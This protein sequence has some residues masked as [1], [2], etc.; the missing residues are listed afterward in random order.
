MNSRS[1]LFGC[2]IGGSVAYWHSPLNPH[3]R[4][5]LVEFVR[6]FLVSFFRRPH[7]Q[8]VRK[9][10]MRCVAKVQDDNYRPQLGYH[11]HPEAAQT[12]TRMSNFIDD[13]IVFEIG[14]EPYAVSMSS[15]EQ[16]SG[17]DGSRTFHWAKDLRSDMRHDPVRSTHVYTMKDVDYHIPDVNDYLDGHS[18]LIST[19][20]PQ[21]VAGQV[22]PDASFCFRD[23]RLQMYIN[24]YA[25]FDHEIWDYRRDE[26]YVH[27]WW[28]AVEYHVDSYRVDDTRALVCISPVCTIYGPAG[29][30]FP[31][32]P[33]K[34]LRPLDNGFNTLTRLEAGNVVYSI[35][36]DGSFFGTNITHQELLSLATRRQ[37][38]ANGKP[39]M[40]YDTKASLTEGTLW[41]DPSF[42]HTKN[43]DAKTLVH[44]YIHSR[45]YIAPPVPYAGRRDL[46]TYHPASTP[47]DEEVKPTMTARFPNL[48][49]P[50]S[51]ALA[52]AS[53][54]E[55]DVATV[56]T[57][58]TDLH[59]NKKT[60]GYIRRY[61]FEFVRSVV[62]P[63][64]VEPLD[65]DAVRELQN[66]PSQ[67]S[68]FDQFSALMD[69]VLPP[70][71]SSFMKKES[72]ADGKPARNITQM[73]PV[74]RVNYSRYT[75][76][77]ANALKRHCWYVSG[78]NPQE[79]ANLVHAKVRGASCVQ[80]SDFKKMD[81]TTPIMTTDLV[82][83]V[84]IRAY[85]EQYHAEIRRYN[86]DTINKP[87]TTTHGV[88]YNTGVGTLS[89]RP[90]TSIRSTLTN[91]FL[92]Y[93]ACRQRGFSE[94]ESHGRLGL[95]SGDDGLTPD[96]HF[97]TFRRVCSSVG[98]SVT[99]E[100]RKPGDTMT[101]LGRIY[102]DAWSGPES[103]C[104][105]KRILRRL[106]LVIGGDISDVEYNDRLRAKAEGLLVTDPETPVVVDA[107]RA[108]LRL[109]P[110]GNGTAHQNEQ[111]WWA[112]YR[113]SPFPQRSWAENVSFV[114]NALDTTTATVDHITNEYMNATT[115]EQLC[116]M[117][118]ILS[119]A[120]DSD[121][122]VIVG[123]EIINESK[124]GIVK[125]PA[126]PPN[127]ETADAPQTKEEDAPAP[128]TSSKRRRR[129]P[130]KGNA[131]PSAE[132][133]QS[134]S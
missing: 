110:R 17:I 133:N 61:M 46:V 75:I 79:I 10:F 93:C 123:G 116:S 18:L 100:E 68:G 96:G 9:A 90:D 1:I 56:K 24:G 73:D 99:N 83:A 62:E 38:K 70:K 33:I 54:R 81:G 29:W 30:L 109:V 103:I 57:R 102:L 114:A 14:A 26:A 2:V 121:F 120:R 80:E 53:C 105:V 52:P 128:P 124:A 43:G 4:V 129:R 37:E 104:D 45:P 95:Y 12:R 69:V 48:Y 39:L 106:P 122:P 77:L 58:I 91:A 11:S 35:A 20:M 59:N 119:C 44:R 34:R 94:T 125:E 41:S 130:R 5:R 117:V 40:L 112:R 108:I 22:G 42:S 92:N 6:T 84:M 67:R 72:V 134:R 131:Q 88:R 7:P 25:S 97:E 111:S 47:P 127:D 118:G 19:I 55:Q 36:D 132:P 82:E 78:R 65:I 60:P 87:V 85:G 63:N 49:G 126:A 71:P 8:E 76:P 74:Y 107:C 32:T 66:R 21:Q 3:R 50:E 115:V 16:R 28:G 64:S 51:H 98:Y 15:A 27:F 89:G 13:L 113:E 101:F 23:N 31:E 86:R